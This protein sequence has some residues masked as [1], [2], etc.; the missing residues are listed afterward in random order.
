MLPPARALDVL[1]RDEPGRVVEVDVLPL[2]EQQLAYATG[3][4]QANPQGDAA[5]GL[6]RPRGAPPIGGGLLRSVQ[7]I[8]DHFQFGDLVA[9]ARGA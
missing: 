4:G 9:A 5:L 6:Q 7:V 1:D 2:C 3:G 8:E